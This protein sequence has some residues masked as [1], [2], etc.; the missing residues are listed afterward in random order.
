MLY[1]TVHEWFDWDEIF[2]IEE[3]S[4]R[5]I[6]CQ[7]FGDI[8]LKD[9]EIF[10]VPSILFDEMVSVIDFKNHACC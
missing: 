9:L 1:L 4:R 2:F 10:L 8:L 3:V 7:N 6:H 5:N